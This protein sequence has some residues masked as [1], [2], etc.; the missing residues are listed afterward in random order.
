MNTKSILIVHHTLDL[1]GGEKL[2]VELAKFYLQH[3]FLV[4]IIIPN[5]LY[6]EYYDN[7]LKRLGVKVFRFRLIN[8]HKVSKFNFFDLLWNIRIKYQLKSKFN[9]I[10]FINIASAT[11]Y[12]KRFHHDKKIFWHVGNLVQYSNKQLPFDKAIFDNSNN[13]IVLINK[14]QKEEIT[15]QFGNIKAKIFNI[16][17]F[18]NE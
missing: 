16:K 14:Y 10:I 5:I 2:T 17:L 7:I 12:Q 4:T 8:R 13:V 18:E 1:G 11:N 6:E 9:K 15:K 3:G